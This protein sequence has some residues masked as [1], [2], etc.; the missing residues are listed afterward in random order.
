M[1]FNEIPM[2]EILLDIEKKI[3]VKLFSLLKN[4]KKIIITKHKYIYKYMSSVK[5][6]KFFFLIFAKLYVTYKL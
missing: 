3:E 6:F 2:F 1:S 5:K 4:I